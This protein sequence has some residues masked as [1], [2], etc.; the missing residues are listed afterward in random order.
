LALSPRSKRYQRLHLLELSARE[1]R[2]QTLGKW[3]LTKPGK[4]ALKER[5]EGETPFHSHERNDE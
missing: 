3:T 4:D 5:S 2:D 1:P